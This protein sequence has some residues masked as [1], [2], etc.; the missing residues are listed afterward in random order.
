MSQFRTDRGNCL[1]GTCVPP[2]GKRNFARGPNE[3][4]FP[5]RFR[6]LWTPRIISVV[7]LSPLSSP[8]ARARVE[9][10]RRVGA[11][12]MSNTLASSL[13]CSADY[14]TLFYFR[15][16]AFRLRR[17]CPP[18]TVTHLRSNDTNI[19]LL[20]APSV[21][22][23]NRVYVTARAHGFHNYYRYCTRVYLPMAIRSE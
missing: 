5:F 19:Q 22:T 20:F 2:R 9:F 8:S 18:L 14:F 10:A 16:R 15:L 11:Y 6:A 3:M 12:P 13:C 1:G 17:A 7:R 23:P 21:T 4:Y